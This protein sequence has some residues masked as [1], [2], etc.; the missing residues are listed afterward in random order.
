MH[1]HQCLSAFQK[2]SGSTMTRSRKLLAA[3]M[4]LI[5]A[6]CSGLPT[7]TF[8]TTSGCGLA[9]WAEAWAREN[10]SS[11]TWDGACRDGL[12][13]GNGTLVANMKSG[14]AMRFTGVMSNGKVK[15]GTYLRNDGW[16][17]SGEFVDGFFYKGTILRPG[18][19]AFYEGTMIMYQKQ[20]GGGFIGYSDQRF[21]QGKLYLS[22]GSYVEDGRWDGSVGLYAL[23]LEAMRAARGV[24]WGKYYDANGV[25]QYRVVGGRRYADDTNYALAKNEYIKREAAA[26][27]QANQAYMAELQ[28]KE[29]EDRRQALGALAAGLGTQGST[30]NRIQAAQSVLAAPPV[31]P[32][33]SSATGGQGG[34]AINT[35]TSPGDYRHGSNTPS[36][37]EAPDGYE[38]ARPARVSTPHNP[39]NS[40]MH[41]VCLTRDKPVNGKAMYKFVNRCSF[42]VNRYI[43]YRPGLYSTG[44]MHA[45]G[46]PSDH[47]YQ[48]ADERFT[49][50]F[51]RS[52][53]MNAAGNMRNGDISCL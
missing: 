34:P 52:G 37:C 31:V 53:R 20:P 38:N 3:A 40:A 15:E 6:S 4:L 13:Q 8:S 22:D 48:R 36:I 1:L 23:T 50:Y 26:T 27:E 14:N 7:P 43:F 46:G 17:Q 9:Q 49:Y 42:S 32:G 41:C 11:V 18:G 33:V 2:I 24:I 29:A 44:D 45:R 19:G 16:T 51:C 47:A 28:R 25:L 30:A 35:G 39:A 21:D 5:L 12:T 10:I